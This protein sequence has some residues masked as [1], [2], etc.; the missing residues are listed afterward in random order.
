[1]AKS[2]DEYRLG[3]PYERP[4]RK[5]T[6]AF[7]IAAVLMALTILPAMAARG[8]SGGGGGASCSVSPGSVASGA[9][10]TVSGKAGHSGNWVNAYLTYSDGTWDF[11]G[12]SV[13]GGGTF[14]LSGKAEATTASL[15]GPFVP[16]TT[17]PAKAEIYTGSASRDNGMVAT[18]TFT[19]T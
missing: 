19:V 17:G 12:G 14:S 5:G 3:E 9:S 4:R 2:Y 13:G 15:W 18:C 11:L 16:A 1:M 8:G 6:K 10:L 7:A